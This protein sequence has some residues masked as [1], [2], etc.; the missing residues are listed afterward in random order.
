MPESLTEYIIFNI[1]STGFT[2]AIFIKI[3]IVQKQHSTFLSKQ[4]SESLLPQNYFNSL[5]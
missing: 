4:Y 3:L 2:C 5:T 1:K